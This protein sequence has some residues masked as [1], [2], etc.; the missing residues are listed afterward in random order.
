MTGHQADAARGEHREDSPLIAPDVRDKRLDKRANEALLILTVVVLFVALGD[1]LLDSPMTRIT[2]AVICYRH[3]EHADPSKLLIGRDGIGPGAIGGVDERHCKADAVQ[4]ELALLR[5]WQY[6]FDSIPGLLLAVPIGW[7]ADRYGRKPFGLVALAGFVLQGAWPQ[8]VTWFWQAFDIRAV[9]LSTFSGLMAGGIDVANTLFFVMVSD[10][11][12]EARRADIFFQMGAFG[13]GAMLTMPPLSAWLMQISSPWI[14][15]LMGTMLKVAGVVA[16]S[17][18]PETLCFHD[19]QSEASL[20][21]PQ[22]SGGSNDNNDGDHDNDGMHPSSRKQGWKGSWLDK[23]G[24]SVTFLRNDWRVAALIVVFFGHALVG[25]GRLLVL[26]YASRRYSLSISEATLLSTA[27][28]VVMFLLYLA[29]FP[30]ISKF[31]MRRPLAMS[32]QKKDLYLAR[33]SYI[34]SSVGWS[35]VGAAPNIPLAA[36]SLGI[37]ALGQGTTLLTRSFLASLLPPH[38]IARAYSLISVVEM[39]GGMLGSP[40]LA[41]IFAHGLSLG[42]QWI[43]LPFFVI[44]LV[45]AAF[46]LVMFAVGLRR[47]EIGCAEET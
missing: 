25:R 35:L 32:A 43:G 26:Q 40:A 4:S 27:R 11:A 17:F 19:K 12:S 30:C 29:I 33:A 31:M 22:P 28:T 47:N 1:E 14:P 39:V 6:S 2:E 7:A 15:A 20:G 37:A 13:L 38:Q 18:C 42:G 8:F 3:Y 5:G 36:V 46:T 45:S 34:L 23:L 41:A 24:E 21:Q 44:G 9:W 10:V 16:L